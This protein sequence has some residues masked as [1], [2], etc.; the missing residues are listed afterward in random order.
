MD[1][2][3]AVQD[4]LDCVRQRATD[5]NFSKVTAVYIKLGP[6][7]KISARDLEQTFNRMKDGHLLNGAGLVIDKGKT[8]ARCRCCGE[9][10]EVVYLKSRCK[11]CGSNYMEFIGSR[12][13]TLDKI[14][15]HRPE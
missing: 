15:G 7:E 10:F 6:W 8:I 4:L 11:R 14:E 5:N 12:G 1:I 9:L 3:L 13:I 2:E